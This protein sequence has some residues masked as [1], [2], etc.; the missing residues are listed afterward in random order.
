MEISTLGFL[1]KNGLDGRSW[2]ATVT[3]Q[4]PSGCIDVV[5]VNEH[6]KGFSM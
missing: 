2:V 3:P 4:C 1:A 5:D 6:E